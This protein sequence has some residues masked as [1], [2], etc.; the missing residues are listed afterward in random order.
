MSVASQ[1]TPTCAKESTCV[2]GTRSW[3]SLQPIFRHRN[4]HKVYQYNQEGK[5]D[6]HRV[7]RCV[8]IYSEDREIIA[9]STRL[10]E[11]R[12][13]TGLS[14]HFKEETPHLAACRTSSLQVRKAT[15]K[16]RAS[17]YFLLIT[18]GAFEIRRPAFDPSSGRG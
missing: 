7:A 14:V 16:I 4:T 18:D 6:N 13:T 17:E 2:V 15:I 11:R 10:N 12:Q 3:L 9:S 8:T 1:V 5:L